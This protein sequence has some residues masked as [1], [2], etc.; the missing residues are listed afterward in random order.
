MTKKLLRGNFI[1]L[2]LLLMSALSVDAQP[3]AVAGKVTDASGVPMEGATVVEKGTKNSTLTKQGGVFQLNVSSGKAHL[4]VSYVGHEAQE[5][6][7]DGRTSL[8][9]A[10]KG[11]NDA[12][13]DIVVIGYAAVKRTDVTGSVAGINQQDIKSRPVVTALDAMQGKIAGVDITSNTRPGVLGDITIRGVR[14]LT[15]SN[16]PLFVVDN[17]PL[18]TGTIDN[19]DPND[20]ETIDVLKD[21]SATAI[22]GSRGPMAL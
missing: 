4:V 2:F 22:Y 3:F 14:S 13:S 16:T 9:V 7:V 15:A 19:I 8:S 20:I 1:L 11:T 17:I 12:L 6:A 10:L 5:I 18:S 21:A